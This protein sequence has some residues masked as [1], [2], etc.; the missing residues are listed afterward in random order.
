MHLQELAKRRDSLQR[1]EVKLERRRKELVRTIAAK[2]TTLDAERHADDGTSGIAKLETEVVTHQKRAIAVVIK[3]STALAELAGM[4]MERAPLSLMH[5]ELKEEARVLK[6]R[7]DSQSAEL[8]TA[9]KNAASAAETVNMYKA[10]AKALYAAAEEK[11]KMT[12]KLKEIFAK[13]NLPDT[14]EELEDLIRTTTAEADG[15]MCANPGVLEDYK[16]RCAAIAKQEKDHASKAEE[17]AEHQAQL[18][19]IRAVWL[20]NL[21]TLFGK[22]STAFAAAFAGIGCAGEVKLTE[23]GE[24]FAAYSVNIM[25]KFRANEHLRQLTASYQSGGERSVSTML[26]LIAL[27]DLTRCPFRVVDEINQGMDP[28]N[29]RKIFQQMVAS[30]CAP[31]TP[32]C[33][34]LTPKLLPQLTYSPEVSILLICNG[35]W[36]KDVCVGWRNDLMLGAPNST[37]VC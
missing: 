9:K 25:V 20:P 18:E 11:A 3:G 28:K 1:E 10:K 2:K 14:A 17:L 29:E 12:D 21:R 37:E 34:L 36:Q 4:L 31:G 8:A 33:F 5:A 13:L 35:P 23:A 6:A 7:L 15:I 30:A 26:Y 24:D 19:A 32:Q 22:V 27:Q 16:N